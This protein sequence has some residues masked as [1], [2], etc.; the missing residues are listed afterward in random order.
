MRRRSP[1]PL[2]AEPGPSLAAAS[3]RL[4]RPPGRPRTVR[5]AVAGLADQGA[6]PEPASG[7]GVVRVFAPSVLP[8]GLPIQA[9]AVYLGVSRRAFYRLLAQGIVRTVRLP[10]C[11]PLVDRLALDQLLETA[12]PPARS[13][14]A[15]AA[16]MRPGDGD[17]VPVGSGPPRGR[18]AWGGAEA[19]VERA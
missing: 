14:R 2:V 15:P 16:A 19:V 6:A 4:R 1:P 17:A 5:G 11:P 10:F 18:R 12:T 9:A 3:R 7:A 8:R 13:P